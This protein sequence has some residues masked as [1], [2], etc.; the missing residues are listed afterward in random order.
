[1]SGGW[2]GG[3]S[4]AISAGCIGR[5][6][7]RRGGWVGA[8][9]EEAAG[10][11]RA[12]EASSTA[13]R[14][15]EPSTASEPFASGVVGSA[16]NSPTSTARAAGG[17]AGATRAWGATATAV[18]VTTTADECAAGLAGGRAQPL[19]SAATSPAITARRHV[20]REPASPTALPVT[21]R[22]RPPVLVDRLVHVAV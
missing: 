18:G 10:S 22:R 20:H 1:T 11:G 14:W 6:Y 12:I 2:P 21:P 19:P 17:A 16:G 15:L 9:V 5:R 4:R 8:T 13:S 7:A 3:A